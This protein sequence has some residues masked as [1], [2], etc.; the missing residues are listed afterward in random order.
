M[1]AKSIVKYFDCPKCGKSIMFKIKPEIEIPYDEVYKTKIMKDKLFTVYCKKCNFGMPLGYDCTYNDMDRHYMIWT[2]PG[3]T[4]EHMAIVEDYN[5]RL[6]TDRALR[7][8]RNDYRMRLVRTDTQLKEKIIIFDENIDD[9]IVEIMKISCMPYIAEGLKIKSDITDFVFSKTQKEG[10]YCFVVSFKD[11]QPVVLNF[12]M[13]QYHDIKEK[14]ADIINDNTVDGINMI[15]A[16]W[17]TKVVKIYMES[18]KKEERVDAIALMNEY[19][20]K[21]GIKEGE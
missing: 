10:Q 16:A 2:Y 21:K 11:R 4:K 17:A 5:K 12:N 7:L 18:D 20:D 6:Q 19:A 14:F 3:L 9:R 1:S 15:N 13:E 8:A